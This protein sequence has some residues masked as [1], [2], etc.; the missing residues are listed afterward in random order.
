MNLLSRYW[1][2]WRTIVATQ[3]AEKCPQFVIR[4][5]HAL[6]PTYYQATLWDYQWV[7]NPDKA[8]VF[9]S[10]EAIDREIHSTWIQYE[11][12]YDIVSK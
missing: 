6:K 8:T 2:T 7:T 9:R 1:G 12:L 3:Q 11:D 10:E 5:R 4:K